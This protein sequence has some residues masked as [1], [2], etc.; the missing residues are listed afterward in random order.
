MPIKVNKGIYKCIF[1]LDTN[2]ISEVP[3]PKQIC[4]AFLLVLLL[5]KLSSRLGFHMPW[6]NICMITYNISYAF[7]LIERN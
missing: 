1:N 2:V 3:D 4:Q 5:P 6:S 7:E